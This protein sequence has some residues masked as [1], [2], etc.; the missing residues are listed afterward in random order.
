[1][2]AKEAVVVSIILKRDP[3]LAARALRAPP[4]PAA[5]VCMGPAC[6]LARGA[7][8]QATTCASARLPRVPRALP[9]M[10]ATTG[11]ASVTGR[12]QDRD[13]ASTPP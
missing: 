10:I 3:A 1:M 4:L 6:G 12:L 5:T 9:Q 11:T 2:E 7:T 8:T 13:T